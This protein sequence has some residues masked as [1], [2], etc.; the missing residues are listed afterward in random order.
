VNQKKRLGF[1]FSSFLLFISLTP[2]V[3]AQRS[4]VA[5]GV[6]DQ[7]W[8]QFMADNAFNLPG[9]DDKMPFLAS[10]LHLNANEQQ[11]IETLF[12]NHDDE[13]L[14]SQT[15]AVPDAPGQDADYKYL[16]MEDKGVDDSVQ[17]LMQVKLVRKLL[18]ARDLD[19]RFW[20]YE[21]ALIDAGEDQAYRADQNYSADE[22]AD[23]LLRSIEQTLE[24]KEFKARKILLFHS[25]EQVEAYLT[26]WE[27][28]FAERV[29]LQT[30]QVMRR[31]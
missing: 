30:H 17:T 1:L 20:F 7:Q 23:S 15:T 8:I 16:A 31:G 12:S 24:F 5:G 19:F 9:F 29:L 21:E 4:S 10:A 18:G 6:T 22:L 28:L 25:T 11:E 14:L 26:H 13:N 2:L 27:A 3:W